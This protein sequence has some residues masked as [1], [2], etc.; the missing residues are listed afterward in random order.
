ME[1]LGIIIV[2]LVV[3]GGFFVVSVY[4]GLQSLLTQIEAAIQEI[5]NQLKR[6]AS[7]IPNLESSVKSYLKQEKDIFKM[8]TDAR[9]Q[10]AKAADTGD[11]DQI[12]AAEQQ[13]QTVLPKLQVAVED[14]PE[15]KSNE[16]VQ[17]FMEELRDTADKVTYARRA[18]ISLTQEYNEKLVTFPSNVVA[19]LF[20]FQK[21]TGIKTPQTGTHVEVADDELTDPKVQ[22]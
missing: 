10:V 22:L 2:V 12:E 19:G 13:I 18:V 4:N 21:Q 17:Q 9:K 16:T 11:M 1:I 7:L 3:G 5:G 6:Q 14:N 20:R 8:L 15:L